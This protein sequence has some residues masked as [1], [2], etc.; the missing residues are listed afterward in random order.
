MM[1]NRI[2]SKEGFEDQSLKYAQREGVDVE[3]GVILTEPYM[4]ENRELFEKYANF[5]S[6][7]PDIFLDLIKPEE[8]NFTL[9]FYQ[10]IVLRA[11]MRFKEVY[12][13]A[14]LKG[15]TPILTEKGMMPIKD[16]DPNLRV[17]SNGKWQEVENLNIRDWNGNLV[18]I[19]GSNCFEED[20]TVTD[21]HKF[22]V[23]R[24]N[25]KD[26]RAGKFWKEGLEFFDIKDFDKREEF[27]KR[28]LREIEPEY[29]E[30]KDLKET[31]WLLSEIDLKIRDKPTYN[32]PRAPAEV[33][34]QINKKEIILDNQFYEWLGIWLAVGDWKEDIISFDI[35]INENKL[36]NRV[37]ELTRYI[38]G[39]DISTNLDKEE[40]V[41]TLSIRNAHLSGFFKDL[42]HCDSEDIDQQN[43]WIP[44]KLLHC[45]PSK[46][47]QLV[48]GWLEGEGYYEISDNHYSYKGATTSNVLLEG[49]KIILYRN[50]INPFI[51]V[52]YAED[53]RKNYNMSLCGP[54]AKEFKESID[55]ERSVEVKTEMRLEEDYPKK[56]G[57]KF[58]M[59]NRIEN[60]ELLPPDYE[61]VYCL[62]L[63]DET[64]N[65]NGVEGHNCRAFSKSFI[66]ILG[67]FLQCI[68]IPETKRFIC[69]P[70]KN[71][72]AQIAKEKIVEIYDKFPLLRRE[73]IG[74]DISDTPGNFGK[75]YVTL[76]FRNRSQ[77]DVVGALDSQRGGRRHG[78]EYKI[79]ILS[80]T[81]AF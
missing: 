24:G 6:A 29:V 68:F 75:D 69:A 44:E 2:H 14:C 27:F 15:D 33:L 64:F 63:E 52:E 46:Q 11:I 41:Q 21:N 72:S 66:S 59:I 67:I 22:L 1:L 78:F 42:F 81:S 49:I 13:V 73:I 61:D 9:F 25:N 53:K 60:I 55:E 47:L 4:E 48:K 57:D 80:S 17:W 34:S 43:R 16:F 23:A 38:F 3:K 56:S 65:I 36:A 5:F 62:Q 79:K 50:F 8:S 71:Q 70:N 54:I 7:Y 51:S 58:Y 35:G 10:R 28:S 76:K 30:A 31:D 26:S 39:L 37:K 77:F 45:A 74:G 19:S 12:I 18:K 32:V 40:N 20:I